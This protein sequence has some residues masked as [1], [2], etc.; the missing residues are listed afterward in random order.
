MY[1]IEYLGKKYNTSCKRELTDDQYNEIVNEYYKKPDI[2]LVRKQMKKFHTGG[3]MVNHIM[4]YYMKDLISKTKLYHCNWSIEEALMYKP[5]IELLAQR[6]ETNKKIYPDTLSLEKKIETAFRLGGSGIASKPSNF[7]VKAADNIYKLYNINNKVYDY[8]CGW[9]IRLLCSLRNKI[10][11]YGTDPNFILCDRL[12][13]LAQEYKKINNINNNI[14]IKK[15]GS[16]VFVKEWENS[17][18]LAFSSPPY[19]NLEDYKIG[20]QSWHNGI[21]YNEWLNEYM[22]KTIFNIQKYLIPNG[23]LAININNFNNN[24]LVQDV[25]NIIIDNNFELINV[26]ELK[27]IT[28]CKPANIE[29]KYNNKSFGWKNNNESIFVYQKQ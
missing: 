2:D 19:Y 5:I 21:T 20:N 16:E 8:S 25:N 9:G 28:R 14:D 15:H 26:H 12:N 13:N 29:D 1:Q 18:G 22:K 24:N 23:Y 10:D 11:Y 4:N 27:N 6:V 7:P 3:V 17:I